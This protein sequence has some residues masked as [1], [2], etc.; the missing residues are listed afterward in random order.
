MEK[1]RKINTYHENPIDNILIEICNNVN[2]Y[3]FKL[4]FTPN[5]IT[6]LSLIVSLYSSHSIYNKQ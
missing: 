3:F 6:T 1:G 2:K 4:N 5:M